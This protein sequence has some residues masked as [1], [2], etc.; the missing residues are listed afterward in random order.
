[1]INEFIAKQLEL[2]LS[3]GNLEGIDV[4]DAFNA[5]EL[6]FIE[7][8]KMS[9]FKRIIIALPCYILIRIANYIY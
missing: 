8:K 2:R 5:I 4:E 3:K 7:I 1:M 6:M 9:L